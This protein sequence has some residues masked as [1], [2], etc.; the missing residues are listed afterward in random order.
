MRT[1]LKPTALVGLLVAV[2]GILLSFTPFGQGLEENFGLSALFRL[3]G[4]RPVPKDIAIIAIDQKSAERLDLSPNPL[5]WPRNLHAQIVNRLAASRASVVVFDVLFSDPTLDA[6]DAL[7]EKAIRDARNV[8]LC[9]HLRKEKIPISKE[10]TFDQSVHMEKTVMPITR[11]ADAAFGLAPF[12]LPRVPIRVSQCWTFKTTAGCRP[13]LPLLALQLFSLPVY[14]EFLLLLESV[15]PA[16]S[17]TL[18]RNADQIKSNGKAGEVSTAIKE[19]FDADPWMGK[20]MLKRLRQE[21][22]V[23]NPERTR[24]LEN[25]IKAFSSGDSIFLNFYGPP[26]TIP[27]IPFHRMIVSPGEIHN[28]PDLSG[29]A[30][31]VGLSDP[32]RAE[33]RDG[34]HTVYSGADGS[35]L[36]GVEIAATAFAN[37]IEGTA[38]RPPSIMLFSIVCSAWGLI[39]GFLC[40]FLSLYTAVA[41]IVVII[42]AYLVGSTILFK[43]TAIWMPLAIPVALQMPLALCSSFLLQHKWG[44]L[45]R[46][47]MRKAFGFFLPDK[48]IDGIIEDMKANRDLTHTNQTVYG[49]ILCSDG[50]Q[51]TTLSERLSPRDLS[52]FLNR[53][54]EV[55]FKPVKANGGNISDI[56]GDSMLAVWAGVQPDRALRLSACNAALE[57]IK[58]VS[59]FNS[60]SGPHKLHTRIGIHYGQ[61][62][63]GNI[64]GVDHFEYRPVGDVVNTASRIEG[65]NKLFGTQILASQEV[66]GEDSGFLTRKIGR[67]ILPGKSNPVTVF[68]LIS[69]LESAQKKQKEKTIIFSDALSAFDDRLWNKAEILLSRYLELDAEDKPALFY[70]NQCQTLKKN[71]PEEMWNGT[72]IV[73]TK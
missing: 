14:D 51:Y 33:Q 1:R 37:L 70:L 6:E 4:A 21:Q 56:I 72:I 9:E 22:S 53:Y 31:F 73:S 27:T 64:G 39:L 19:I 12:P 35:Q 59:D 10:N 52:L 63:L 16:H 43:D 68:E 20:E 41:A 69:P 28:L 61:L 46:L 58:V 40:F 71:P 48:A 55:V 42:S 23:R 29:K 5:K 57:I 50:T 34:F 13:T 7:L 36:N 49:A 54:Y 47:H 17:G 11:F 18:P 24:L 8:I 2:S 26:G 65:L 62:L 15:N 44:K 66:L 60:S 45:E 3:R 30:I 67:V 32:A 25:L 38:V